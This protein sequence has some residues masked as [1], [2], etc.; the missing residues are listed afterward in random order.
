M[1]DL[2][3]EEGAEATCEQSLVQ[4][5]ELAPDSPDVRTLKCLVE[6]MDPFE[7]T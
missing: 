6:Q 1:T 4:G 2:C 3:D 7:T 5:H